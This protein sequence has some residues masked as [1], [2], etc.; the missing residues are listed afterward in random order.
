MNPIQELYEQYKGQLLK[1]AY[2][3]TGSASDAED[4]V[5]DVFLKL[6]DIE[7]ERLIEPRAYLCKMVTNR[8]LDV[9]KSARKK[10]ELYAGEWLPEPVLT[11]RDEPYEAVEQGELLSYAMLVLLERLSITERAVFVL[12]EAFGFDYAEIAQLIGKNESNCR[13]LMSRARAKMGIAPDEKIKLESANEAWVYRFL[14]ALNQANVDV[15]LSMLAEDVVLIS[16]GGGKVFA[17]V[18][19]I[20]SRDRVMRFL[21]GLVRNAS[22]KEGEM[23]ME[24]REI[25]NQTG[26]IIRTGDGIVTVA[27]LHVKH[28][29]IHSIFMV[30]NPEKLGH[31]V[32]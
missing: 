13:K 9:F 21:F 27:L 17:A 6:Y 25:N 18:H 10:R 7:L 29:L 19:A 11:S 24:I 15:V 32:K 22:Q 28:H 4:A 31:V 26:L 1:L 12:R 8:C 30:R 23:H 16:D 14:E 20:E 5:Q 2:Q 3:L